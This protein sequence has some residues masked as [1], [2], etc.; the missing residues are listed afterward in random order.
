VNATHPPDHIRSVLSNLAISSTF[1]AHVLLAY[2]T[3]LWIHTLY[4]FPFTLRE[5]PL[6]VN[7]VTSSL[8]FAQEQRNLILDASSAP[9]PAPISLPNNRTSLRIPI[10]QANK[11]LSPSR[12]QLLEKL[13]INTPITSETSHTLQFTRYTITPSVNTLI[14]LIALNT[15]WINTFPANLT[16]PLS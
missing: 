2:P 4:T 7:A 10:Y 8:N 1:I 16:W 9:V 15:I 11:S 14:A 6:Y 12:R 3:T 13:P 5:A